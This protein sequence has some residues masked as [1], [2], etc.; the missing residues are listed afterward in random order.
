MPR[1]VQRMISL[2][3]ESDAIAASMPNFSAWVRARLSG[4]DKA[5]RAPLNLVNFRKD[6]AKALNMAQQEFGHDCETAKQIVELLNST[7]FKI[8]CETH[9]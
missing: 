9:E 4:A 1:R 3:L 7:E 8:L 6:L 5:A 2:D